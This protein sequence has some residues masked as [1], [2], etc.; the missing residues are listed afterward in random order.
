MCPA[1]GGRL[2]VVSAGRL[3]VR[4]PDGRQLKA[5]VS[6]PEEGL[7]L[8]FHSGAPMGLVPLPSFIDPAQCGLRTVLYARPGYASSSPH[9]WRSVAD[10][11]ADSAVVLDAVGVDRFVTLGWSAGG[12]HALACASLLPDRCLA[13]AVVGSAVPFIEAR[14]LFTAEDAEL[15]RFRAQPAHEAQVLKYFE[16][17][18][19]EFSDASAA[20]VAGGFACVADRDAMTA[21][22]A[23]WMAAS[24]RAA[25]ASG[26]EGVRGDFVAF[27]AARAWGFKVSQSRRVAIWHGAEDPMAPVA[28]AVWLDEHIPDAELHVLPDEGHVSIGLRF[29]E[30]FDDL[31]S[32]SQQA[33]REGAWAG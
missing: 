27:R 17:W 23:D 16:D 15:A 21:E 20:T 25:F 4:T 24:F 6:G 5:I 1:G 33:G 29:R 12:P 10:A 14:E 26:V 30:I 8:V 32:R 19:P 22:F 13:T 3:I 11:A 7:P 18:I 9:P 28:N 2:I 31:I